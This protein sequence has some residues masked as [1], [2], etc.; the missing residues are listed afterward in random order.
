MINPQKV[1]VIAAC[2][3]CGGFRPLRIRFEGSDHQLHR[4]NIDQIV[5]ERE[6]SYV[7]VEAIIYLCRSHEENT[8]RL[9]E[10]RYN[11]RSHSWQ[12]LRWIC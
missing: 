10:L 4:V 3:T 1:E 7:G 5:S 11:I 9:F 12:L 6:V 8:E 2:D